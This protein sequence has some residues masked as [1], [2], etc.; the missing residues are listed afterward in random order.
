MNNETLLQLEHVYQVYGSGARRFTAVEDVNLTL[1]V[2]EFVAL[3]GPSGCGKSTLLRIIA[4]LQKPSQ[5]KVLYRG[6][7]LRGVNPK[8]SIIF[9]TFALFPWLSVIENVT[10]ALQMKG[11]EEP[12]RSRKAEELLD[13]VGLDGFES[14]Y[15]RELS[16]GMR[17]K[18]GFARAMAVEPEL[19]CMDEPFSA[20]DV[21]SAETLRG[22]LLELWTEGKIPTK[23]I[24]MV[25][26][27]IE[28]AVLLADRIVV[29]DKQPG[30]II[31]EHKINLPH[32][33]R[34]KSPEFQHQVDLVYAILA[35]Q[36]LSET[37]ELGVAPGEIGQ[38]RQLPEIEINDLAGLLEHFSES[39]RGIHDL[40]LLEDELGVDSEYLLRLTEAAEILGFASIA[41]GDIE[42]TPIG[43]AF[44]EASIPARKEI[45]A[46]RA[47]RIPV[48]RWLLSMLHA[49]EK[50]QLKW[51]LIRTALSLEF[52]PEETEN[53]LEIL[54]N[55]GRYGALFNY[56]DDTETLSL[57]SELEK[58]ASVTNG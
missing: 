15:P 8:A 34:R 19:L 40:Y 3:L 30:R 47:R 52:P 54:I 42:A 9:Q 23:S 27:S 50:Q 5:G 20:L 48:I 10:L 44:A 12:E 45:F 31:A 35:G 58:G 18:V 55:W 51:D 39:D 46:S 13:R 21:L 26:H 43:L 7:V 56:D 33:R 37:E 1:S 24:L 11:N 49:S 4:G 36:T 53:Q 22:E 16:G 38:T 25:S 2:G 57:E 14:A 17:Q 32:P 6:E 41:K 28:E 29:M